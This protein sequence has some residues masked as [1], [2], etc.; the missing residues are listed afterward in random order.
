MVN[1]MTIDEKIE[2][3]KNAKWYNFSYTET[4]YNPQT[5]IR[6][7]TKHVLARNPSEAERIV[8]M[9]HSNVLYGQNFYDKGSFVKGAQVG[10]DKLEIRYRTIGYNTSNPREVIYAK[11]KIGEDVSS[12]PEFEG[13]Y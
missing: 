10:N 11:I 13:I 8:K 4:R 7:Y 2:K 9:H 5:G 12:L 6:S 1:F 3:A